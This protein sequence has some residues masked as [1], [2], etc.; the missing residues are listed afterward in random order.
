MDGIEVPDFRGFLPMAPSGLP[1]AVRLH[2]STTLLRSQGGMPMARSMRWLEART[3]R[4]ARFWL[5]AHP[6]SIAATRRMFGFAPPAQVVLCCPITPVIPVVTS[7]CPKEMGSRPYVL[8]V[9]ARSRLKGADVVAGVAEDWGGAPADLEFVFVGEPGGQPVPIRDSGRVRVVGRIPHEEMGYWYAGARALLAPCRVEAQGL[10]VAEA[11]VH[12]CP[13]LVP[14]VP[15]YT[16]WH[17]EDDVAYVG[18]PE[19]ADW[20]CALQAV[21]DRGEGARQTARETGIRL[22]QELDPD[23][24]AAQWT[25][26]WTQ[27]RDQTFAA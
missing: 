15:P 24:I 23:R 1:V 8:F 27:P 9:G 18:G 3:L 19:P 25:A 13:V 7:V 2:H 11:L 17:G 6:D 5:A 12:G 26:I 21:L 10:A 14:R 4:N 20:A 22:R 16:A